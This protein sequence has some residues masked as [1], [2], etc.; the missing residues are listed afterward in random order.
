MKRNESR[1]CN[2]IFSTIESAN[3]DKTITKDEALH[4][5]LGGS[6]EHSF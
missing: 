2:I 5:L 3:S 6:L 1:I 4:H